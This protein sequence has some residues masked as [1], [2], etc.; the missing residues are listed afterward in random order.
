[1]WGLSGGAVHQFKA[2]VDDSDGD[3]DMT[4]AFLQPSISYAWDRRNSV[5]LSVG[6][7]ESSYNF[8]GKATVGNLEPWDDIRDY[9]VSLPIRF[10]PAEKADVILIPSW[11]S[12]SEDGASVS[13]ADTEGVLTAAGWRFSDTL[14]LGPGFGWFSELGGGSNFFPVLLIDWQISQRFALTTG[15]GLGASQGPGLT[16]DYEAGSKWTVGLTARYEK[17]RF[18]LDDKEGFSDG[19]GEDKSLPLLLTLTYK[20]WPMTSV[21]GILGV[22]FAGSLRMEDANGKLA[23]KADYDNA[24]VIGLV[25]SS[26]F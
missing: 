14:T 8:S 6:V 15:R 24:P 17:T 19:F 18:L 9:R 22:E 7:G 5:S 12:S 26:R 23:A 10:S 21:S 13:K 20:P 4:R 2:D 11:R 3:F 16:L 25:F 1:M